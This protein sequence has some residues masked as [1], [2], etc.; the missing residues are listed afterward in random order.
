M[1]L[2]KS[3]LNMVLKTA[4][5]SLDQREEQPV[6]RAATTPK[7]EPVSETITDFPAYFA[8]ILSTEFPQYS[9][10]RNVPVTELAGFVADEFQLYESRPQQSYKAEW[11]APYTFVLYQ[12]DAPVGV[13]MLGDGSSHSRNVKYLI[14]RMYAKKLGLPY[15]NFYT[16]KPNKRAYVI[17]RIRE[18]MK[19]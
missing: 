17:N 7:P 1:S 16:Q 13:V 6:R 15:I 12:G 19:L 5:E 11:G 2:L 10:K 14:S 3:I 4:V 8:E 9:M 18:F